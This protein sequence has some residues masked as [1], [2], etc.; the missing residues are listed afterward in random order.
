[1]NIK[2]ANGVNCNNTNEHILHIIF[3]YTAEIH[4]SV[5]ISIPVIRFVFNAQV[6]LYTENC[7]MAF[8]QMGMWTGKQHNESL[9]WH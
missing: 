7:H 4:V 3:N 8:W 9:I 2:N 6:E 5:S 1:M